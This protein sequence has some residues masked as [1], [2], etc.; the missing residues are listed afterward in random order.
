MIQMQIQR[1]GKPLVNPH[2]GNMLQVQS[3]INMYFVMLG[4]SI[5]SEL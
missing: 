2:L 5:E 1:E 3:S 4:R